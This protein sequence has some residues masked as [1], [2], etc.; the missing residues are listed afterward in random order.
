MLREGDIVELHWK[1]GRSLLDDGLAAYFATVP[2]GLQAPDPAPTLLMRAVEK[3]AIGN[4]IPTWPIVTPR[5]L[6]TGVPEQIEVGDES[7]PILVD[8]FDVQPGMPVY[9]HGKAMTARDAMETFL[10]AC[11]IVNAYHDE[12]WVL[13]TINPHSFFRS[14]TGSGLWIYPPTCLVRA[15]K[16][17][18]SAVGTPG[19]IAPEAWRP[20][21]A[22][23]AMDIYA[24]G[25]TLYAWLSGEDPFA[26]AE[27]VE[28]I[29]RMCRAGSLPDLSKR[30]DRIP[31]S[32][33]SLVEKAT[34]VHPLGR[35]RKVSD[36]VRAARDSLTGIAREEQQR[37]APSPAA[38][39]AGDAP[40]A[41]STGPG[42]RVTKVIPFS[43]S[44]IIDETEGKK[45]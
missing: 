6:D 18:K 25:A 3:D 45:G 32:A 35:T 44:D 20:E 4:P 7:S 33:A 26:E 24:L 37:R 36:L 23:P 1:V 31:S 11:K 12:G 30:F 28:A 8:V 14:V 43:L 16:P 10:D 19:Y 15:G 5:V 40:P 42:K 39:A 13:R 38:P 27:D 9:D 22:D 21:K 34:A 17:L 29:V 41:G 2:C